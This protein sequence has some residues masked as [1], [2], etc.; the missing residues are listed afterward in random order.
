MLEFIGL[1]VVLYFAWVVV[2][3]VWQGRDQA[4]VLKG[5][6]LACA[7]GVDRGFAMTALRTGLVKYQMTLLDSNDADYRKGSRSEQIGKALC[8]LVKIAYEE[9]QQK[10]EHRGSQADFLRKASVFITPQ[11]AALR[12]EG[13]RFLPTHI[14]LA[15]LM[16]LTNHLTGERDYDVE[17]L[18][19]L[20]HALFPAPDKELLGLISNAVTVAI[21][22]SDFSEQC[23]LLMPI[24]RSELANGTGYYLVK[25]TR[26]V[27]KEIDAMFYSDDDYDPRNVPNNDFL[28]V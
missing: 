11:L 23:D 14:T 4:A 2:K 6:D 19:D 1:V 7:R 18:G 15:Y 13:T 16:A 26:K 10:Q 12:A 17:K 24:V 22:S 20:L 5:V 9:T 27:V 21:S 28:N 3:G 25:Y 8:S